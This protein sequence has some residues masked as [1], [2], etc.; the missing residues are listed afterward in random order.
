MIPSDAPL[1]EKELDGTGQFIRR[2]MC[3]SI[4]G[5][6]ERRRWRRRLFAILSFGDG[7]EGGCRRPVGFS[8]I[9]LMMLCVSV[10]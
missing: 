9:N 3:N 10:V 8:Q 5:A 1:G 4:V 7:K 2:D 6:R